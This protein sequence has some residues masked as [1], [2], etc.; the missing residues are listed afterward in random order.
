MN[1]KAA[2]DWASGLTDEERQHLAVFTEKS[3]TEGFQ[4]GAAKADRAYL[5]NK[6]TIPLAVFG[7]PAGMLIQRYL[8][9]LG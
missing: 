4:A 2:I 5:I 3:K 8:I 1:E 7:I 6:I 9:V